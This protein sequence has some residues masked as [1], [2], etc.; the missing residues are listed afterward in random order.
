MEN[1]DLEENSYVQGLMLMLLGRR[2]EGEGEEAEEWSIE[3]EM[4]EAEA[5]GNLE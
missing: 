4:E 5:I 2:N 1:L 3:N